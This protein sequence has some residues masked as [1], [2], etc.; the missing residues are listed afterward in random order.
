MMNTDPNLITSDENAEVIAK[1]LPKI[2]LLTDALLAQA[3]EVRNHLLEI[4]EDLRQYPDLVHLLNDEQIAP[5]YS[6]LR[7]QTNVVIAAKAAKKPA[8]K[9]A[10]A[11][12]AAMLNALL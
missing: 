8:N 11:D 10:S 3:P 7:Q 1:I 2:Q 12:D 5:I 4:N 9:K 6:A